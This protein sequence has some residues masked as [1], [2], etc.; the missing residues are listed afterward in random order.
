MSLSCIN[1]TGCN[2]KCNTT[3]INNN[4]LTFLCFVLRIVLDYF[5]MGSAG[6]LLNKEN[7]VRK[8]VQ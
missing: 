8:T 4:K 2:Y 7:E 6:S 3:V 5:V 1:W